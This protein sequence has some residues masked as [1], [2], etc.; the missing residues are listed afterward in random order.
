[1]EIKESR[2]RL[3]HRARQGNLDERLVSPWTRGARWKLTLAPR[4][5]ANRV[6]PCLA[7][8]D[9][10]SVASGEVVRGSYGRHNS[11]WACPAP[12]LQK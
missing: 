10:L 3:T 8:V 4:E 12:E 5:L 9:P 6:L 11:M 2:T 7:V 1:M